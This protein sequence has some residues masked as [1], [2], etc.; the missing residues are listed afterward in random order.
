[1]IVCTA[2]LYAVFCYTNLTKWTF[3]IMLTTGFTYFNAL[4]K[5][6]TSEA[7][8]TKADCLMVS[9]PTISIN[10][11]HVLETARILTPISYTCLVKRTSIVSS[12]CVNA[13]AFLTNAA[14]RTVGVVET[15]FL[16]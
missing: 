11:A 4:L 12:A 8:C 6:V 15:E 14:Q 13:E 1:M 2:S 16:G 10:S 3:T 9:C 5:W 7:G